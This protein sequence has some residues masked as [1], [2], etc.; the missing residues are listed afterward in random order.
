VVSTNA[1]GEFV[2]PNM[3]LQ[4][5]WLHDLWGVWLPLVG[6][7]RPETGYSWNM[8]LYATGYVRKGDVEKITQNRGDPRAEFT[9][10]RP[11]SVAHWT[12]FGFLYL[13]PIQMQRVKLSLEAAAIYYDSI[14]RVTSCLAESKEQ[15]EVADI[16][17][18]MSAPLTQLA[19]DASPTVPISYRAVN[20]I[21]GVYRG[22]AVFERIRG[23]LRAVE[24]TE[25]ISAGL[26]C[27]ALKGEIDQ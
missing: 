13:A 25:K 6:M 4:L 16:L 9:W 8:T 12:P 24:P 10:W 14:G 15:P 22:T 19:C 26:L 18:E 5:D 1:N 2:I 3:T 7:A 11:P 21:A 17:K 20:G 23:L 27:K